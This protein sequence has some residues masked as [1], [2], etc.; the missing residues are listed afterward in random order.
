MHHNTY[1]CKINDPS[2]SDWQ[3]RQSN[4][5]LVIMNLKPLNISDIMMSMH[6][7]PLLQVIK[8]PLFSKR[9]NWLTIKILDILGF[10]FW[11]IWSHWWAK[12]VAFLPNIDRSTYHLC[13]QHFITIW[14][15]CQAYRNNFP[16]SRKLGY[17][18]ESIVLAW[19]FIHITSIT[20]TANNAFVIEKVKNLQ[21]PAKPI[22]S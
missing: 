4:M 11:L 20:S 19:F 5:S 15:K 12:S 13:N 22:L 9:K 7:C 3:W 14:E 2:N 17:W 10:S 16:R 18:L 1:M 6:I 8:G 21:Q